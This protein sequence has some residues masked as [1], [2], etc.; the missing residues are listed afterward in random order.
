M[1]SA[2]LLTTKLYIPS[3]PPDLAPRP[4]LTGRLNEA[5]RVGRKLI[6]I[7][8]PAGFGK[9]TL[10][11][12][13]RMTP[14]G[15][16]WP[17]VWVSLD[18]DDNDPVRFWD[19]IVA[20]LTKLQP[21]LGETTLAWLHSPQPPLFESILASLINDL[22][23]ITYDFALVLDDY[24]LIE[25]A[26]VHSALTFLLDH[27]PPQMHLIIMSRA[28]PPLPLARWRARRQLTELR[29]TD[30]RFTLDEA[31]IFLNQVMGL[32]LS[33]ADVAAL[34]ARTEGWI[35]GL[36]LAAISM[37]ERAD[38]A[39]FI[40]AFTGSHS[41][42]LDYLTEEVFQRQP[43]KV[44]TFLLQTS[45][46]NR[47][48]GPLCD[49]VTGQ[50][51]GQ[52]T[53]KV[54]ERSNLFIAPMDDQ[55]HWYRYHQLFVDLLRH[56]LHQVQADDVPE[57]HHRAATWYEHAGFIDEAVGHAL[58]AR[59]F[60][61][62]AR[63][64]EQI[65]KTMFIRGEMTALQRWLAALPEDRLRVRPQLYLL[66]AWALFLTGKLD[67]AEQ[68]LQDIEREFSLS[69]D[70]F[71]GSNEDMSLEIQSMLSQVTGL[72]AQVALMRG[73]ISR[74]IE[75]S[76]QALAHL[77]ESEL[78]IR[79]LIALNLGTAYWLKGDAAAAKQVLTEVKSIS[80]T[81][82]ASI[83]LMTTANLAELLRL[84]GH[85]AQAALLYQRALQ[86]ATETEGPQLPVIAGLAHVGLGVLLCEWDDLDAATF[87]LR[88][89]IEL[90]QQGA[91]G[92]VLTTGYLGL[93]RVYHAQKDLGRALEM[94]HQ[95][96]QLVRGLDLA[97][98][99]ALIQAIRARLWL[100]Q[101]NIAAAS[102]W[103]QECELDADNE[104]DSIRVFEYTTLA[105]LLIAQGEPEKATRLLNRLFQM[106]GAT[107]PI[108]STVEI[109][110]LQAIA[111][112]AQNDLAQALAVLESALS[113]AEPEG[114]VRLFADEGAPMAALLL[115]FLE[116]RSTPRSVTASPTSDY[117]R[118]LLA[119][120]GT[121]PKVAA[122]LSRSGAP[123]PLTEPLTG[124]ELEV[125]QLIAAGLSNREIA[126]K[127]VIAESTLKTHLKNTYRKL[128]ARS[129][130]QAI[131]TAKKLNLL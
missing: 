85:L 110:V 1:R 23:T 89:G 38:S 52:A 47:L 75:M 128:D 81:A 86:L 127:L 130:T 58:A 107:Q 35:T 28:D 100:A 16:E 131:V 119:A 111:F 37:R 112:Q 94:A 71:T 77:P 97:L 90:G 69:Q 73:D 104:I 36:Q 44:Q 114:Y 105:R 13:W 45:I 123:Q 74:A 84:Q 99:L 101:G 70:Q 11:S 50:Q 120:L 4:R 56:R 43:D 115:Q 3:A 95:A 34:E 61:Y 96:E 113:L 126:E 93:A 78:A 17:L 125:L 18:E 106:T 98:I 54:L 22:A 66:S 62:A 5:L 55:R 129:R 6:L 32:D 83:A 30:L 103:A 57:L 80:Q 19:Y 108:R 67:A 33:A 72:Y 124:R 46:L 109:L 68:R 60:E 15:S 31:A 42:I 63:L 79:S 49:A 64:I 40:K 118:K 102:R 26:S 82:D 91:G 39:G 8:A 59:D 10:L 88:K 29:A 65:S 122:K 7:S 20:A 14:P 121:G 51:D 24:H 48:T 21:G 12:Q 9:T 27:L 92:R 117:L 76:R 116:T 25:D 2:P 87:H 53:L 41:Y